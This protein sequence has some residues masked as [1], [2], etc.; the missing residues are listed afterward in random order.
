MEPRCAE[1][2]CSQGSG[3]SY[4]NS[5]LKRRGRA[6]W[7]QGGLHGKPDQ[8]RYTWGDC[9]ATSSKSHWL[10]SSHPAESVTSREDRRSPRQPPHRGLYKVDPPSS[11]YGLQT[12][13]RRIPSK[14]SSQN[15][16]LPSRVWQRG[17]G[18]HAC[19]KPWGCP[20]ETLTVFAARIWGWNISSVSTASTYTSW[21][22]HTFSREGPWGSQIVFVTGRTARPGKAAQRSMSARA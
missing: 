11:H 6:D 10:C 18:V 14:G 7:G 22:R 12:P 8:G 20:V 15:Y 19:G 21:A 16:P 2:P 17:L 5:P 4:A 1:G 3:F 9:I 13:S